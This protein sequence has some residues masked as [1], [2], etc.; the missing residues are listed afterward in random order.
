MEQYQSGKGLMQMN[1]EKMLAG[2]KILIMGVA[3]QRSIAWAIAKAYASAGADLAFSYQNERFK[4]KVERLVENEIPGSLLI[5]C[6]VA[7]DGDLENLSAVLQDQ[8]GV[9]HGIVHSLA[10]ARKEELDG[11][12]VNTSR[13]GF[14]L[15]QNI[16]AYSLTAVS[17]RLYPLMKKGGS[18]ITLTFQGSERVVPNYNVMGVAKAALEAS[19]RYLASDLGSMG[20]RVNAVSAGPIRTISAKGVKDFNRLLEGVEEKT[21]LRRLAGANEV[22]DTA[23]FLASDLSSAVT[24]TVLFADCG[25]HIMGA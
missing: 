16:S 19:V 21:P 17:K 8:W 20:I 22:A 18:I 10:Y 12:F 3:N 1:L 14:L 9:L 5:P 4:G 7:E 24:G 11:M 13:E 23:L 15:A 6:D 25:Y 2:K